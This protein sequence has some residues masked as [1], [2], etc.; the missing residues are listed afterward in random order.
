AS[1]ITSPGDQPS[2]L[3]AAGYRTSTRASSDDL[4]AAN[5]T[6]SKTVLG[7]S[8]APAATTTGRPLP[9]QGPVHFNHVLESV[10]TNRIRERSTSGGAVPSVVTV[11]RSHVPA[12]MRPMSRGVGVKSGL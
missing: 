7:R 9:R 5:A 2:V 8:G 12:N 4:R 3:R 10:A 11:T 6:L 1:R